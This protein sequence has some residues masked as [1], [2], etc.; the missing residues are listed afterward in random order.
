MINK[1]GMV[2][3]IL[4]ILVV[5]GYQSVGGFRLILLLPI[6]LIS[7]FIINNRYNY[8]VNLNVIFFSLLLIYIAI[9]SLF[10]DDYTVFISA[11]FFG[12][13]LY[14]SNLLSPLTIASV[15]PD[16][17]YSIYVKSAMFCAIGVIVQYILYSVLQIEFMRVDHFKGRT[18]FSFLWLDYSYLSLF[19]AS[20]IPLFKF[21]PNKTSLFFILL[22]TA[23]AILT[24]ARTG[25]VSLVLA[26]TI[27]YFISVVK[28][29]LNGKADIKNIVS[30]VIITVSMLVLPILWGALSDR[31]LT[32]NSSGR[33][34]GYLRYLEIFLNN[35]AIFGL[36][37]NADEYGATI[38]AIPHN[39]FIYMLVFGGVIGFLFFLLWLFTLF[40]DLV[41]NSPKQYVIAVLTVFIGLQFVPSVFSA[42]FI[43]FLFPFNKFYKINEYKI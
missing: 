27:F 26:C 9:S 21:K 33:F 23:G 15:T 39:L 38:E 19:I 5:F 2:F 22:L 35:G 13:I 12:I 28:S 32:F 4:S 10:Y 37:F 8:G 43:A 20:A 31:D 7:Y 1:L 29:I 17:L 11:I 18:A 16:F 6:I 34:D 24:S 41:V 30:L 3:I 40:T 14:W 42:Y 36:G 25:I